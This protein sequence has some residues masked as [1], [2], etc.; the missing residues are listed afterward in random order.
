MLEDF[1]SSQKMVWI[2]SLH[3]WASMVH[4]FVKMQ[5]TFH[6]K[7]LFVTTEPSLFWLSCAPPNLP[8]APHLQ[9]RLL[10]MNIVSPSWHCEKHWNLYSHSHFLLPTTAHCKNYVQR[11]FQPNSRLFPKCN[12]E[13]WKWSLHCT[14]NDGGGMCFS[15]C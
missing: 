1:A 8:R 14:H 7:W 11:F 12:V 6:R 5:K 9:S 13:C 10:Q 4:F 3:K 2:R 15:Q